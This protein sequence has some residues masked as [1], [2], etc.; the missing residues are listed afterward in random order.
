MSHKILGEIKI[1]LHSTGCCT[2]PQIIHP[3]K[4]YL[5][6]FLIALLTALVVMMMDFFNFVAGMLIEIQFHHFALIFL[7]SVTKSTE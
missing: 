1:F 7:C 4:N 6:E 5:S 3:V 2:V